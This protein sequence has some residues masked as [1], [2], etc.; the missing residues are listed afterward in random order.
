[1]LGLCALCVL[2]HC[3]GLLPISVLSSARAPPPVASV[4]GR[5]S[6]RRG[7]G[8]E[9]KERDERGMGEEIRVKM[10]EEWGGEGGGGKESVECHVGY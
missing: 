3:V 1:M 7:R 6:K 4:S 9:E 10:R 8:R 2:L 5:V